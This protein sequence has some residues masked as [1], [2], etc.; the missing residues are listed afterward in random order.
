MLN[1]ERFGGRRNEV[2][3]GGGGGGGGGARIFMTWLFEEG[4][5]DS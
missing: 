2:R 1:L 5:V 4:D 3:G